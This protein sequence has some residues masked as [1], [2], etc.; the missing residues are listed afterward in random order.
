MRRLLRRRNGASGGRRVIA[1]LAMAF[2]LSAPAFAAAA[3]DDPPPPSVRITSPLGRSGIADTVRIA[4]RVTSWRGA[5]P[6]TV[7]FFVDD[8]L[9]STDAD[10]PPYVA[11][12]VDDNPFE[13]RLLRVEIALAAGELIGDE[14]TLEPLD[15]V[16][17][18]QVISVGLEAT[19]Q[20]GRG[21]Y[22]ANLTA[23]DF[24]LREDGVAQSIDFL[25]I[26]SVATTFALLID[27]SQS[28]SRSM[29]IV[30]DAAM[31]L[32]EHLRGDDT[33]I[34][35][36]FKAQI[37][38]V[39]GPTRDSATIGE[40]VAAIRPS[41]KTAILD[42]LAT[43]AE[44]FVG[45]DRR[46]IVLVTD[47]YDEG[48]ALSVDRALERLKR[49]QATVHV[50]A[51]GGVAGVSL[52]GEAL[53][54]RLAAETGGRVFFPWNGAQLAAAHASIAEDARS[55]YRMAYTPLNQRH[56]GT[57]RRLALQ[58]REPG[59][60][61]RTRA[62]FTA[63]APPPVHV[64]LEFTGLSTAREYLDVS[65]DELQVIEDGVPQ[66][67]ESF[68]EAVA[69]V[70][71][72]LA[73]DASG[74]MTRS[75][76]L[77]QE[78]VRAFVGMLRPAD[79]LGMLAFAD[80]PQLMHGFTVDREES[81]RAIAAYVA[82][83]G[84]A[85]YDA[86]GDGLS[87]LAG[88]QGRRVL[89]LVSDGRDENA[90]SNGPGSRRTWAEVIARARDLDVTVYSIGLGSRVDV[91]RLDELAALT[92]GEAYVAATVSDLET[93]YQRVLE[94]LRRRYVMTY[95]STNGARDGK[96][97]KVEIRVHTPGVRVRSRGGYFAPD[98][99]Q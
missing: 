5:S 55:R 82:R 18:A 23:A 68:H 76:P 72:L 20:D 89:V 84:T 94:E 96:W 73:L 83:G 78:A 48:S 28:M 21:L 22:V 43:T 66:T 63:P 56:D 12:W 3:D 37:V 93:Q 32:S 47:G 11:E 24:E 25:S 80:R 6:P 59:Y 45:G 36:P 50:I 15:F 88:R 29:A 4:A 57:W 75:A 70:S 13:R 58:V 64:S 19:V 46:V 31:R 38:N 34:I 2:A 92:G 90:K 69:P 91:D 60:V 41:G 95:T 62:G 71:I 86:L 33:M 65:R 10:G 14:V 39:T 17:S 35:A 61:V 44:R 16:E 67:L 8:L 87:E 97:R 74:S 98:A 54:R 51:I 79:A 52:H 40:A 99:D 42:A 77:V 53:I 49:A 1:A 81:S 26:E 27:T 85:L 7:R 9:L 30:R